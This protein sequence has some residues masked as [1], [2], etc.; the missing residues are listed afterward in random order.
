MINK[1]VVIVRT[2]DKNGFDYH[3]WIIIGKET[4]CG[5]SIEVLH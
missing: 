5:P 2:P 3:S 1:D 4:C